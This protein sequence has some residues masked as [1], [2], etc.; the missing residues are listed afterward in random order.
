MQRN[1]KSKEVEVLGTKTPVRSIIDQDSFRKGIHNRY[2]QLKD[3][4]VFANDK[5]TVTT[6]SNYELSKGCQCCKKGTW[7]CL[8]VGFRCNSNCR[9]CS[10][11]LLNIHKDEPEGYQL[12][13][14]FNKLVDKIVNEK[15]EGIAYS[16]GE[17]LL[18][19]DNKII[20]IA[21]LLTQ[22]K[23]SIYQWLYTNGK[24]V[25][26]EKMKKLRKAGIKEVRVNLATTNFSKEVMNKIP[27]IKKIIGK[28]TVEIP[29]IPE[30][31][32]KLIK[33]MFIYKIINYGVEQL[34]L[35]ELYILRKNAIYYLKNKDVYLFKRASVFSPIESRNITVDI[36]EYVIKNNLPILVND[37][38][39][40]AKD[41][42]MR[43]KAY[44][45][46]LRGI[47]FKPNC[48]L[49]R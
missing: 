33:K 8:F 37:C 43:K 2:K 18:Y 5:M 46:E 44:S 15:I 23:P 29:S 3:N 47:Y 31:H 34:N 21:T 4:I 7:L 36:I 11:A 30:V 14:P 39:N 13:M 41:L 48:T 17:P 38:S 24:L 9:F 20:P 27:M 1:K 16:G 22:K 6:K 42:Q 45:K 35:A 49:L 25:D 19:L 10:R 12:G 26:A 40:D 28:V 32:E